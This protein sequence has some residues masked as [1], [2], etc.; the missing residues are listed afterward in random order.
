ME[1]YGVE[2]SQPTEKTADQMV[3]DIC[4]QDMKV[5]AQPGTLRCSHCG[6]TRPFEGRKRHAEE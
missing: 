2:T 6:N 1:K 3:C 4:G 5:V